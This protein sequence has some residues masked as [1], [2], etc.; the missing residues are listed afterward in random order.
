M[1]EKDIKAIA[2]VSGGLDSATA[3]GFAV[4]KFRRVYGLSFNYGQRHS[5]ELEAAKKIAQT[6]AFE[7]H[8]IIDVDFRRIG[9]SALTSDI[10]V[11][12][13]R[14]LEDMS[15]DIPVTYVPGR[16]TI[17]LAFALAYAEVVGAQ[18]IY[19]GANQLDYSG[20]PD[21]RGEFFE[22]FNHLAKFATKQ[23]VEGHPVKV[24]APLLNKT[25]ADIIKNAVWLGVDLGLTHSC[26]DPLPDGTPCGHC[27]SCILRAK[28]FEEA[29]IPDPALVK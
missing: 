12:K 25:K 24:I 21:C 13:S 18:E 29:G 10:E 20:Y 17:F 19:I 8:L 2:L 27:D 23:G 11:P 28:G 26:Y 3:A 6:L 15:A 22:A 1:I 16:N 7:S 9:G 4:S 5:I 14:S